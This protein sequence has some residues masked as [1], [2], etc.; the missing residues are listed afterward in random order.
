MILGACQVFAHRG[1]GLAA[2]SA[3][4][5]SCTGPQ[6]R[7]R[8]AQV[9][10]L[11]ASAADRRPLIGR[12]GPLVNAARQTTIVAPQRGPAL[13]PHIHIR[14]NRQDSAAQQRAL[15]ASMP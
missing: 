8:L 6:S 13:A 12:C 5:A 4:I 14:G 2:Y 15:Y 10:C 1:R 11:T 9:D 3:G 7:M